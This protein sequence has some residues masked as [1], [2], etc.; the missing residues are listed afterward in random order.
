MPDKQTKKEIDAGTLGLFDIVLRKAAERFAGTIPDDSIARTKIFEII[1]GGLKGFVEARAERYPAIV[2]ALVEKVTDY[3]DFLSVA[4]TNPEHRQLAI[5]WLEKFLEE[6]GERL[7][8][9]NDPK[10]E[11]ERISL[12]LKLRKGLYETAYGKSANVT[13]TET[14]KTTNL[15]D[16]I[17]AKLEKK[18]QQM[19]ERRHR[20]GT[21]VDE[22]A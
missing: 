5:K 17:N 9:A 15:I 22:D 1:F 2:S 20:D 21:V 16:A 19:R 14:N 13:K 4:I 7:K 6:A 8:N 3:L 11:F 10:Q 18:L 12:E